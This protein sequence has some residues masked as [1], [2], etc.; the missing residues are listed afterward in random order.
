VR[1][2]AAA[3]SERRIISTRSACSSGVS[4][5]VPSANLW[6]AARRMASLGR[7]APYI[8]VSPFTAARRG[9]AGWE[10]STRATAIFPDSSRE[11]QRR[12]LFKA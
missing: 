9:A 11:R 3:L 1:R 5:R 8:M 2:P 4:F 6:W 12:R 7:L 10:R